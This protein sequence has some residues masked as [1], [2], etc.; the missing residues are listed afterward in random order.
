MVKQG[1][2]VLDVT[3]SVRKSK[4]GKDPNAGIAGADAI[5][6]AGSGCTKFVCIA[7]YLS[8]SLACKKILRVRTNDCYQFSNDICSTSLPSSILHPQTSRHRLPR[9]SPGSGSGPAH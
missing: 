9:L 6:A 8:L 7:C 5:W 3:R 1:G 2:A 4:S